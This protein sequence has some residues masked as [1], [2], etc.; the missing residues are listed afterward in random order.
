MSSPSAIKEWTMASAHF[1]ELL[2]RAEGARG[3]VD[4]GRAADP[5]VA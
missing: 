3:A 2:E 4:T 1:G 5:G